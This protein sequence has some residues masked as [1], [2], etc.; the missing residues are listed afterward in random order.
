MHGIND[1]RIDQPIADIWLIC[2]DNYQVSG[3]F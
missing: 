3:L 1:R 2:N